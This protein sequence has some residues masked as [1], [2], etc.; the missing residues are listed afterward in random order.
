MDRS[1]NIIFNICFAI[2]CLLVFCLIF[3]SRLAV[4]SWLQVM[5]RMHPLV[6]HFPITLLVLYIFWALFID[7]RINV[8]DAGKKFGDWLLLLSA[9]TAA[10]T[11]LMGL[12]LSK[13]DGYDTAALQWHKWSGA[14]VSIITLL[15]Y[16]CREKIKSINWLNA[17][18]SV[19]SLVVI[20]FAGHQGAEISHGQNFLL[21]PI[22][23]EK[24]PQKVLMEN[25][26]VY[27]N[28][29]QPVLQAKCY[30]CHNTKKARGQLVMETEELLVKGGKNGKL[31]DST[32]ANYGLLLSRVHLPAG[33][34]K[35][36]PP[37]G[38]PQLTDQE[39]QI[40]YLWIKGGADFKSKVMD[41]AATDPLYLIAGSVFNTIETDDYDFA[42]AADKK[43]KNLN[44]NYRVVAPL[45][46]GSPALGAEFFSTQSYLPEQLKELLTVK[47]QVVNLSL[48]KMPVKDEE[49]KI[50][51]QFSSLR[52]LNLSFTNITG[53]AL[54]ELNKLKELRQLSL[55]GTAIKKEDILK[56][57]SLKKLSRLFIWNTA[58]TESDIAVLKNTMQ[59]ITF[60]KGFNGDTTILKLTPP[61]L[62]N[63]EQII[64]TPVIL[65]LRHYINGV[66]IRYTLDGTEPDSITSPEYNN[67][68]VLTNNVTVKA[69]AFKKGWVSS[70]VFENYFFSSKYTADSVINLLPADEQYK[71]DGPKTLSDLVKGEVSN[72]KSGKW[73][74][75]R[76]N[77][78][79]TLLLF[80]SPVNIKSVTLSTLA[81]IGGYIMPPVSVEVWG[82]D[83][84]DH[85]KLLGRI[86][87][88]QPTMIQPAYLK[89]FELP[90]T[91]V[92]LKYLKVIAVPVAK[93]PLWHPGK[94]DKGWVFTDEVFV[95]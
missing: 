91:P 8:N 29:V 76:K 80:T 9:F 36:M 44:T 39:I 40:L 11:A 35:H 55:S 68:I 43:I 65:K 4:P 38:K 32:A 17:S 89:A 25:A 21:A 74:G 12:F 45:A 82:G 73:L 78:M 10:F 70:A 13:E 93:L 94:G 18:V 64:S 30:S 60:E 46:K 42:A 1:R 77:K 69:K 59:D 83:D 50:I 95:N 3:E 31:W 72:F 71:G 85:L 34:K 24:Q 88:Q 58:L 41:L 90:F 5:G 23:P 92:T 2:N 16:A 15:W 62:L 51:S 20:I 37:S 67:N 47:E 7:K 28:M 52:K 22:M 57:S 27:T 48:N 19:I 14:G 49:L 56:L 86:T 79:E 26:I 87:P 54:D 53:S 6:L 81:D 84:A 63:E 33:A 61:V 66:S 75:F